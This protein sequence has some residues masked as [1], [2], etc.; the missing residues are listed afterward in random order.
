MIKELDLTAVQ[1]ESMKNINEKYKSQMK[2]IKDDA[3]LTKEQKREQMKPLR[4]AKEAEVKAV[5]TEDQFAKLQEMN[6]NKKSKKGR[7]KRG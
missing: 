7:K 2:T 6:K 1:V 4:A 3:S 5:L